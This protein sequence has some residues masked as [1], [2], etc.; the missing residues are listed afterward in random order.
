[1]QS[2]QKVVV[3]SCMK[4]DS[5]TGVTTYY[6]LLHQYTKLHEVQIVTPA[7]ASWMVRKMASAYYMLFSKLFRTQV[8]IE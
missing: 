2:P 6:K 4:P 8:N 5:K 3:V 1:M 7:D